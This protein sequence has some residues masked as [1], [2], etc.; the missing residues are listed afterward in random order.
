M[1]NI[2]RIG[3]LVVV[4]LGKL[5]ATNAQNQ[6]NF[7]RISVDNGLS[8]NTV[9]C[10]IQDQ[11]G[12]LWIGTEDGLNRYDGYHFRAFKSHSNSTTSI[13]NN[14]I[15][16]IYE[17]NFGNIWVGTNEGL[18]KFDT[19]TEKFTHYFTQ[20]S[21]SLLYKSNIVNA[22]VGDD[23]G[24]LYISLH[25]DGL[26][27][28]D[29]QTDK[30][31]PIDL[32]QK[33]SHNLENIKIN[34]LTITNTKTLFLGTIDGIVLRTNI[35][36]IRKTRTL[37][38]IQAVKCCNCAINAI[39]AIKD[40]SVWIGTAD[41]LYNFS[42]VSNTVNK[43]YFKNKETEDYEILSMMHNINNELWLGTNGN[44]I[45]IYDYANNAAK[46]IVNQSHNFRSVS[47]NIIRSIYK[48]KAE[49]IWIGTDLGGISKYDVHKNK[50]VHYLNNPNNANS[51]SNNMVYAFA[52]DK[53]GAVWV[54]TIG[55]GLN[56]FNP[57]TNTF[58]KIDINKGNF[59][60]TFNNIY[61]LAV[62]SSDK[63]WIGSV[64][65]YLLSYQPHND[66][67]TNH[68]IIIKSQFPVNSTIRA[69]QVDNNNS[70]YLGTLGDG[71][72]LYNVKNQ[73]VKQILLNPNQNNRLAHNS[74]YSI[75]DFNGKHLVIGTKG[76]GVKF[77]DKKSNK[78]K[79]FMCQD[80][81]KYHISNNFIL[82][83][84]Q[85]NENSLWLGTLGG[86]LNKIT[87]DGKIY[88]YIRDDGSINYIYG[89][90]K[91]K[92]HNLWLSTSKGLTLF[93]LGN[94]IFTSYSTSDGL[95]S[96]EFN[97][98]ACLYSKAGD[99][100]F[101]GINGF[102]KF[103]PDKIVNSAY[104]PDVV[105]TGLKIN[106]VPIDIADTSVLQS[107]INK[108]TQLKLNYNHKIISIE[109]AALNYSFPDK[110]QYQYKLE[111]FDKDWKYLGSSN[112][113]TFTNLDPGFYTLMVKATNSDGVWNESAA[114]LKIHI[115]APFWRTWLFYSL[116][117]LI[118]ILVIIHFFRVRERRL[119]R[120]KIILEKIVRNRTDEI[121]KKNVEL[122][123]QRDAIKQQR[124]EIQSQLK[125]I[126]AQHDENTAQL[127]IITAQKDEINAQLNEITAQRDEINAQMD[128]IYAQRDSLEK[129]NEELQFQNDE[130]IKTRNE[131]EKQR[132][133][134]FT[135]NTHITDSIRY[136]QQI[137]EAILPPDNF[138]KVLLPNSFIIYKPK[139][140]VSGDFYW[141]DQ[142]EGNTI[143]AVA[144]CTGHGVPGAL[145]SIVCINL[146]NQAVNENY[147]TQPS[148]IL[149][150]L[151]TGLNLTLT[152][153]DKKHLE[154]DGLDIALCSWNKDTRTFQYAGAVSPLY[155]VR[156]NE[157]IEYSAN[158]SPILVAA[159][160]ESMLPDYNNYIVP[161]ENG[162]MVYLFTDG[163]S[164][165]FGGEKRKKFLRT[166]FREALL[167]VCTKP[168]ETQKEEL[169]QIFAGW[170]GSNAQTDDVCV[171]G[172]KIN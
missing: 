102:N 23:L 82:P 94:N 155:V 156:N 25:Q 43:I 28:L 100:Y 32:H 129:L 52:E 138:I 96:N 51:L 26:Y 157:I 121:K 150:Y 29:I 143:F 172:I 81:G 2:F 90:L 67:L 171:M 160:N 151:Y 149:K 168:L 55:G 44:G 7:D 76:G 93:D 108:T 41:G 152:Q 137:Q 154:K 133:E 128:E 158:S 3:I 70:L 18:N 16:C 165:Q 104:L 111:G 117:I 120:R 24:N 33:N 113:V 114:T 64:N 20:V 37:S 88:H 9:T 59:S 103:N 107:A 50:F 135:K 153:S 77:L 89:I 57:S 66:E 139:D 49:I 6:Y 36:N 85:N 54:G 169:I 74:V 15:N 39:M 10:I 112:I 115:Q 4:F 105:F 80:T 65:G 127:A 119:R 97:G 141:I 84:L 58:T 8:Q 73:I 14:F 47:N 46:F 30:I 86:G 1:G 110:I 63:I 17:D 161:V 146:L 116:V 122:E 40:K 13:S 72:L 56:K 125:V 132:N 140:I 61:S 124:D 60:E 87:D 92:N 12:F 130:L 147:L 162:D 22:L 34:S 53:K 68:S 19:R 42:E 31:M 95:Q 148:E 106:H 71:L 123:Y 38:V 164:D 134:I 5:L 11:Q 131:I 166:R 145:M 91:D 142:K 78:I 159:R 118:S 21:D 144:D 99:M 109:F 69:L 35:E 79:H 27:M 83:V 45:I 163:F 170:K 75:T 101:G 167:K 126:T 136:A 98:G 62:D 48:D